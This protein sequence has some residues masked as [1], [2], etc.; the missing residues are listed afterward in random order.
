[1]GLLDSFNFLSQKIMQH[2]LVL[3]AGLSSSY[4]INYFIKHAPAY[5]WH[6]T[7]ADASLETAQQK[8]NHSEYAT[9]LQ[10]DATN[11]IAIGKL[12]QSSDIV[13]SLLPPTLHVL[14]AKQCIALGKHLVTASYITDGMKALHEEALHAGVLLLN[15]CGLDPGIDHLSAKKII[16]DIHAKGGEIISFKSHCGGL[17]APEY[18]DNPWNYKFTWNPRNVVL[19]GQATAKFLN[20]GKLKYIIP[21][22]IFEQTEPVT[23]THYGEFESYANRDS[24][25]YIEPYNLTKATTVFRG[26]LR[27]KGY[28]Q[29]WNLLV[30]LGLT[31]D[32]FTVANIHTMRALLHALVPGNNVDELE[33][34]VCAFLNITATSNEFE[35]LKWLGLF[36]NSQL[37]NAEATPAQLLQQLLQVKWKLQK[38]ELDMIV[39]KHEFVYELNHSAHYLTSELVVKGENEILTAMAKTVGLPMAIAT[40]LILQNTIA[41]RGVAMPLHTEFY[42]P[43]LAELAEHGIQF[44]E[45]TTLLPQ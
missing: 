4:L 45:N 1:M 33:Q 23:I 5:N 38:S 3:G 11:E 14:I 26:T 27:K 21:Q 31:D 9:A 16:D 34:R 13:V 28:C 7:V 35:K 20:E 29:T 12:V 37:E 24:L 42:E 39:M 44:S 10:L 22:H 36:E 43:M 18:D 41:T 32:T 6:I 19:S 30:K 8:I 17:V 40:K 15:E 2:I 25:S